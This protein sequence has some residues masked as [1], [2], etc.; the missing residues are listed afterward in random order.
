MEKRV[1][2]W[3]EITLNEYEAISEVLKSDTDEIDKTLHVLSIIDNVDIDTYLN[4]PIVQLPKEVSRIAGLSDRLVPAGLKEVYVI[5][6][7]EYALPMPANITSGQFIDLV[8]TLNSE[9]PNIAFL[10]AIVLVPKGHTYGDDYSV[11]DLAKELSYNLT[12]TDALAISNFFRL[13]SLELQKSTLRSS[14]RKMK[15]ELKRETNPEAAQTLQEAIKRV[16]EALKIIDIER[17]TGS[18]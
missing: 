7:K 2:K 11:S 1:F 18:V 5:N 13:V 6:E 15:K 12:I 17:I 4:M 8:N 16:E 10:C 3:S 9:S 14:H